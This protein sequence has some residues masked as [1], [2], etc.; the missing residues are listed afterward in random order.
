MRYLSRNKINQMLPTLH[1]T[2]CKWIYQSNWNLSLVILIIIRESN[3]IW[4]VNSAC[5]RLHWRIYEKDTSI[6]Y[7]FPLLFQLNRSRLFIIFKISY[8][9]HLITQHCKTT[10][11]YYIF[12]P[13]SGRYHLFD[14]FFIYLLY[15]TG[16]VTDIS[17]NFA[18][19]QNESKIR[20]ITFHLV[21]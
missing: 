2:H 11:L 7:L 16:I 4:M 17:R 19:H 13:I 18:S 3:A 21:N 15:N 8:N 1:E 6:K 10:F 14:K 20:H 9:T 12:S 5:R